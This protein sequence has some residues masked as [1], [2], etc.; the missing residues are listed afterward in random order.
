MYYLFLYKISNDKI[1]LFQLYLYILHVEFSHFLYLSNCYLSVFLAVTSG[2]K[3]EFLLVFSI[4]LLIF[5][6]HILNRHNYINLKQINLISLT[7]LIK[8][9]EMH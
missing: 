2:M 3:N 9:C 5:V 7:H 6:M 4:K 1:L 8:L